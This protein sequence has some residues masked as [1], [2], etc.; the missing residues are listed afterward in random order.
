LQRFVRF[1]RL[2]EQNYAGWHQVASYADALGC[3]EKSLTR[4]A[5]EAS[6]QN[7]KNIIAARITLEA[8]RLLAHTD[9]PVYLI[10]EGLG[11]TEATNFAKFFKRETGATPAGFR[12]GYKV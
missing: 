9:R 2:V 3:T 10:A 12:A 4:A 11:F 6:G 1:R 8:K 7:A 5:Q